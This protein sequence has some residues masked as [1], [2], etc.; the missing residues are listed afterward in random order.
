M[1]STPAGVAPSNVRPRLGSRGCHRCPMRW[2]RAS[3]SNKAQRSSRSCGRIHLQ[4]R[5]STHTRALIS[6]AA[7]ILGH[8]GEWLVL[9]L[10]GLSA[11]IVAGARLVPRWNF[12]SEISLVSRRRHLFAAPFIDQPVDLGLGT[13]RGTF[14]R[15]TKLDSDIHERLIVCQCDMR[16]RFR[17]QTCCLLPP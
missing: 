6:S 12:R 11:S 3:A 2:R 17:P 13:C 16:V 7:S 14:N 1:S 10:R 9:A 8:C 5:L 4:W 15:I